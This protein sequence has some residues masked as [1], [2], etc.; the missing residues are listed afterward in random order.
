VPAV[1]HEYGLPWHQPF[2]SPALWLVRTVNNNRAVRAPVNMNDTARTSV[3]CLDTRSG[4][5]LFANDDVPT[6]A[7]EFNILVDEGKNTSTLQL[8][9]YSV[10][11]KFSDEPTPPAPPAQTGSAASTH[12]GV[13][14]LSNVAGIVLNALKNIADGEFHDPFRPAEK[15]RAPGNDLFADPFAK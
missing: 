7:N 13:N 12:A 14:R 5:I 9:G 2:S 4:Q 15:P 1:I 8:P 3:L 11:V 6:Q 10:T